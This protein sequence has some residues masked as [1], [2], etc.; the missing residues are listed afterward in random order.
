MRSWHKVRELNT[1]WVEWSEQREVPARGTCRLN[2][3]T[4]KL[5]SARNFGVRILTS[6]FIADLALADSISL[7]APEPLYWNN[8]NFC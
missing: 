7:Y 8:G 3:S 4:A 1:D 2:C 5:A 6:G